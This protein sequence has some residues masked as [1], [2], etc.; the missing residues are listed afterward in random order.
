MALVIPK[1]QKINIILDNRYKAWGILESKIK[2]KILEK[3]YL[4][5]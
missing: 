2:E 1:L 5:W 3:R 4:K